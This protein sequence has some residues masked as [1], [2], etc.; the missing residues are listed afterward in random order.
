MTRVATAE[1]ALQRL[2]AGNQRFVADKRDYP[3]QTPG[4][5]QKLATGQHPFAAILGCADSRVPPEI[6]FDQ[7]LG[8]LF[9]VRVAGHFADGAVLGSLEYAVEHLGVPLIVVLG[10]SRCGAV[11]AA[12]AGGANAGNIATLVTAIQPAI[13]LARAEPGELLDNAVRANVV[14]AV[15]QLR[16]AARILAAEEAAGN[17]KVCGAL[18]DLATGQ[19]D[20]LPSEAP[21]DLILH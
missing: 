12:I 14:L 10:H 6:I 11:Q 1:E 8:Q 5:R 19:V 9:T 16:A 2:S 3:N 15:R 4:D 7:G 20:W 18:Y 17:L 21:S 13:A